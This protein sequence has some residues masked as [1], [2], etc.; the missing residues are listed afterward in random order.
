MGF[1]GASAADEDGVAFGIQEGAG[2]EFADQPFI[3]RGVGKDKR[4]EVL[5]QRELGAG[6]ATANT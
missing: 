3:D 4:I 1:A 6:E 2:G 5:E